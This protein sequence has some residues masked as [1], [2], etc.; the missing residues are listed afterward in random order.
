MHGSKIDLTAVEGDGETVLCRSL[1]ERG[2]ERVGVMRKMVDIFPCFFGDGAHGGEALHGAQDIGEAHMRA[3]IGYGEVDVGAIKAYKV[4]VKFFI[5]DIREDLLVEIARIVRVEERF[6]SL[7]DIDKR[8]ALGH[9][10][11]G[12]RGNAVIPHLNAFK[13]AKGIQDDVFIAWD[14]R[15]RLGRAVNGER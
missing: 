15:K 8:F 5:F 6:F 1:L 13:S 10:P 3:L 2:V 4:K 12:K 14:A 7:D 11:C 9:V